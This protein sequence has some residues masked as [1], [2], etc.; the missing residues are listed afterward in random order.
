MIFQIR[1][2]F[3]LKW[4]NSFLPQLFFICSFFLFFG[5]LKSLENKNLEL[6][7]AVIDF[8]SREFIPN[9][10]IKIQ[11]T[12]GFDSSFVFSNSLLTQ[13]TILLNDIFFCSDHVVFDIDFMKKGYKTQHITLKITKEELKTKKPYQINISLIPLSYKTAPVIIVAENINSYDFQSN[14]NIIDGQRLNT[15]QS[16]TLAGTL[17]NEL[18]FSISSMGPATSRPV[19]RG[20]NGNRI[21]INQDGM[22]LVDISSTSPD[23]AV[24]SE[25][26]DAERIEIIRGPRT[27]IYTPVAISGVIDIVKNKIPANFPHAYHF[28]L[29]SIYE[30]MNNGRIIGL[31]AELP[32]NNNS[33]NS[34]NSQ[35]GFEYL[36][37]VG[38]SYKK[39]D[40]IHSANQILKNTNSE[41]YNLSSSL[42]TKGEEIDFALSALLYGNDY[43]IPGGFVGAHPNGVAINI[44]KSNISLSN[45]IHLHQD[46]VDNIKINLSR[47]YYFHTEFEKIGSIGAQYKIEDY[48]FS[49]DF[50]QKKNNLFSDGLFG[51]SIEHK[52]FNV[53]GFV[54]TPNTSHTNFATYFFQERQDEKLTLQI[55]ARFYLDFFSPEHQLLINQQ[56]LP[57]SKSFANF[58]SSFSATYKLSSNYL[59]G[60][61]FSRTTKSPTIEELYSE[62]PHLAAYSFEVGNQN[63]KSEQGWGIEFFQSLNLNDYLF[64]FNLYYNY[65]SYY[66]A[67]RNT[68]K[69]N[70]AQ[71]LP[72]YE[73]SG[74]KS[75]IYGF[76]TKA[77]YK[78]LDNISFKAS[79]TYTL[80][81]N[82]EE[83]IPLP[84]IPPLKS[85]FGLNYTIENN[86]FTLYTN[87]VSSQNRVDIFEQTT[88]GY[89]TYGVEYSSLINIDNTVLSVSLSLDNILNAEYY[90]H[91]SRIKAIFPEPGRN[92]RL[93]IKFIN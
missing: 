86:S 1:T 78:L 15:Q 91:L 49:S 61:I 27:L 85:N 71:L 93:N 4:E 28:D 26:S 72:I 19:I 16:Q 13:Q 70:Y 75:Q 51:V 60:F 36:F 81:D 68:G 56:K 53:G 73:I 48:Y 5:E 32:F 39:T 42:I 23:H 35:D 44:E 43:K 83:N 8:D 3:T 54:F 62:G 74:I 65:F 6:K 92:F 66:I 31:N 76:D 34:N 9:I 89:N 33:N 10:N 11:N 2:F 67:P 69:I 20:L 84:M 24:T 17:K 30:S 37:K 52:K 58:S 90:N 50:I 46:F 40:D 63:L 45:A 57:L 7:V 21:Q 55:S 82:L 18:G 38:T 47:S 25:T 29:N 12:C 41:S 64:S 22:P 77:E 79:L 87:L 88:K 14:T 59:T 80:G